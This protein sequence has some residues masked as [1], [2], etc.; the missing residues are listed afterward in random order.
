M[1]VKDYIIG[2]EIGRGNFGIVYKASLSS[3]K[4]QVFALK[5]IKKKDLEDSKILKKCF[6]EEIKIMQ[7]VKHQNIIDFKELVEEKESYFIVMEYCDGGDLESLLLTHDTFPEI[8]AVSLLKQIMN[9]FVALRRHKVIH[10]DLKLA[11]LLIREG[12]IV[13]SD[14]GLSKIGAEVTGTMV[15][16]PLTMAPELLSRDYYYTSKADLWSI[17]I[18]FYRMIYG[19]YP[20][21]GKNFKHLLEDIKSNSGKDMRFPI[22]FTISSKSENLIR[23]LLTMKPDER[24]GWRDFFAHSLFEPSFEVIRGDSSLIES[25]MITEVNLE[26]K[27]KIDEEFNKNRNELSSHHINEVTLIIEEDSPT[28]NID[29]NDTIPKEPLNI[30]NRDEAPTPLPLINLIT[31]VSKETFKDKVQKISSKEPESSHS[32]KPQN[33]TLKEISHLV[34]ERLLQEKE[35]VLFLIYSARK[36]RNAQKIQKFDKISEEKLIFASLYCVEKAKELNQKVIN[37]LKQ[38]VN[39]LNIEGFN[40]FCGEDPDKSKVLQALISN[41][42]NYIEFYQQLHKVYI[43]MKGSSKK[44]QERN[45]NHESLIEL[46]KFRETLSLIFGSFRSKILSSNLLD[47]NIELIEAIVRLGVSISLI[48]STNQLENINMWIK[49]LTQ[50]VNLESLLI[51]LKSIEV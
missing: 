39:T 10:R 18:C 35:K 34:K 13:I 47:I 48:C 51:I 33:K 26:K 36:L 4:S 32:S 27:K 12:K 9:G 37:S 29:K 46:E 30:N 45:S 15:G 41:Q 43:N 6:F 25:D 2:R 38:N 5:R 19:S 8:I 40:L 17:G 20:F 22:D 31:D 16:T 28:K 14:F 7:K 24:I 23:S 50:P 49:R 1:Q 44:K 3:D 42:E 21:N 11:N